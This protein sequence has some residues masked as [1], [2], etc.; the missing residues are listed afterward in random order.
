MPTPVAA[1]SSA[2]LI[3]PVLSFLLNLH[4]TARQP[5]KAAAPT[6]ARP[7]A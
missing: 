7:A 6:N 5:L 3:S 4:V 2:S 1:F